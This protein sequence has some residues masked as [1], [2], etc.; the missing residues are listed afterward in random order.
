MNAPGFET[1]TAAEVARTLAYPSPRDR[2]PTVWRTKAQATTP[3][4]VLALLLTQVGTVIAPVF[5]A[6]SAS[7]APLRVEFGGE[8]KP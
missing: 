8:V 2:P 3:A 1:P 7:D 5:R 6:V 4:T